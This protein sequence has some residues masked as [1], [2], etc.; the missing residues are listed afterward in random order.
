MTAQSDST[1]SVLAE[2]QRLVDL[3]LRYIAAGGSAVLVFGV[4]QARNF[5]FLRAGSAQQDISGWL[6]LLFVA[7]LG[8]AIYAIHTAILFRFI[9]FVLFRV[10]PRKPADLDLIRELRIKHRATNPPHP[11]SRTFDTWAAQVHFLYCSAWGTFSAIVLAKAVQIPWGETSSICLVIGITL[12]VAGI[13]HD[14]ALS[15]KILE[16]LPRET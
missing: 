14:Y 12:L 16:K 3:T 15:S 2:I 6:V 11:W 1:T 8:I 7:V 10:P 9:L 13:V 5:E 4:I